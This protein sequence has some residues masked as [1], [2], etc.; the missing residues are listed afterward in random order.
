[1]LRAAGV[2]VEDVDAPEARALEEAW[3]TW[4]ASGGRS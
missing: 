4:V 3:R 1:M 2:D